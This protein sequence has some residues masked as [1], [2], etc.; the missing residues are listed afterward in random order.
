MFTNCCVDLPCFYFCLYSCDGTLC[1]LKLWLLGWIM[2]KQQGSTTN[3]QRKKKENLSKPTHQNSIKWPLWNSS[4]K[5]MWLIWSVKRIQTRNRL[6]YVL[7][8]K[9]TTSFY[10]KLKRVR[11]FKSLLLIEYLVVDVKRICSCCC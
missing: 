3:M 10:F 7:L 9:D 8:L 11:F 1:E 4:Y 6:G 2:V 5:T